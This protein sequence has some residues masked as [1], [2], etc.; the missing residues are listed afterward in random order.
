MIKT[1]IISHNGG[2]HKYNDRKRY[3]NNDSIRKW[4]KNESNDRERYSRQ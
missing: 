4:D 1:T 2:K 3:L